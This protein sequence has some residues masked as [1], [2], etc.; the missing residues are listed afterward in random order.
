M[1]TR[2][3]VENYLRSH[4]KDLDYDVFSVVSDSFTYS[5]KDKPQLTYT[6]DL[7]EK[8]LMF[9]IEGKES[10][11]DFLLVLDHALPDSHIANYDINP[12]VVTSTW[13]NIIL[14][15]M[16]EKNVAVGIEIPGVNLT[17]QW[18]D[19]C[20]Q[21]YL[22]WCEHSFYICSQCS[23]QEAGMVS[24]PIPMKKLIMLQA[25]FDTARKTFHPEYCTHILF[26]TAQQQTRVEQKLDKLLDIMGYVP[27]GDSYGGAMANFTLECNK[28]FDVDK[29]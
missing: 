17:V 2:T 26:N 6:H 4:L 25:S 1:C 24:G 3:L 16:S 7:G 23:C 5:L 14:G 20:E 22:L 29:D 27:G 15:H 13:A 10:V 11:T 21:L 12:F 8:V 18:C 19:Y 9:K 28:Q